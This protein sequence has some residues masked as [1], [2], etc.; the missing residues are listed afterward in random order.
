MRNLLQYP[1]TTSEIIELLEKY[2]AAEPEGP[3][4][5]VG[6]MTPTILAEAIRRI[7]SIK[8]W[9]VEREDDNNGYRYIVAQGLSEKDAHALKDLL[10]RRGHKQTYYFSQ[11]PKTNAV[12]PY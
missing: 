7:M 1:V 5:P 12:D 2:I 9:Y 3:D 8:D 6:D 4:A 11:S 10:E